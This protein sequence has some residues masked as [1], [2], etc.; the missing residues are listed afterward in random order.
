MTKPALLTVDDDPQVLRAVARDLRRRYGK[1]YSVLRADSGSTAL[2]ALAGLKERGD[3]VALVLSDHRMP[4]MQGVELLGQARELHPEAKRVLLTAYADTEAAIAAI[5]ESRLDFYLLKPWDPPEERLYPVLDDLLDDWRAGYRPGYGGVRV[6]GH[7]WSA[8]SHGIKSFLAR[9]HVPYRFFDVELEDEAR[10]LLERA[11][12]DPNT[13]EKLPLVLLP[14]GERLEQPSVS[15]LAQQLGLKTQAEQPFYDLAILGAGPA[16]LAAAVY[17][18]SEGLSTVLIEREAPGGQAGTTSRIEN[19]LGFPSGLSGSDLARRGLDQ[20]RRF[21][22]EVLTPQ[23]AVGV[24]LEGPYKHL[25]LED[26]SVITSHVLMIATGVA[27]RRLRA[28]GADELAGRGVYYGAA[29]TE[30]ESC[31]DEDVYVVGAANSAGQAAL[32]FANHARRVIMLVRG[33]SIEAKMSS[34]LVDRLRDMD[35][36]EIRLRTEVQACHGEDNLEAITLIDREQDRS[37]RVPANSLFI[38]IG[39]APRT[40]WLGDV[41]ARDERGFILS[42]SDLEP[43]HLE[44]WPLERQPYLFEASVPGIFATGDVRHASVKRVASAVGEGSVAVHFV[45]RHLASL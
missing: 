31:Q 41:V 44:G 45:H 1:E 20:A 39:A 36:V 7:R 6:V 40:D 2:E 35:N 38:F 26:G 30:A 24:R 15:S 11:D 12:T 32:A 16:G 23:Q 18:A 10:E 14:G 3:P 5:N 28:P 42:G 25:E 33:T 27:W 34:Y 8:E 37:E 13:P 9:N 43:D 29:L 17:G 22:V 19:Y 21:G 4:K